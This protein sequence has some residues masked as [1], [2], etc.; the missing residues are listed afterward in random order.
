MFQKL[1]KNVLVIANILVLLGSFSLKAHAQSDDN[2][3]GLE[4]PVVSQGE[5]RVNTRQVSPNNW[6]FDGELTL[7][8]MIRYR[9]STVALD[10]KYKEV[11]TL[12]AGYL[13][14]YINDDSKEENFILDFGSSPLPINKI[15]SKLKEGQNKIMMVFVD[16]SGKI[17]TPGSK[18]TLDFKFKNVSTTPQIKVIEPAPGT[19]LFKD[20]AKDFKLELSNFSLESVN[21]NS[22]NRG[23]IF[24]YYDEI[25]K[26]NLITSFSSSLPTSGSNKE[27]VKFN[28][29]I[30][31]LSKIPDKTNTQF[32]FVLAKS[33]DMLTDYTTN[34]EVKTNYGNSLQLGLPSITIKEPRADKSDLNVTGSQKFVISVENFQV[35]TS[36]SNGQSDNKSGYI[37][38]LV[39][40]SPYQ[41]LW[42]NST[43]FSLD[44][45]RF[46]S[47]KEVQKNIK[48][49]LVNR[50]FSKL[51]TPASDTRTILYQPDLKSGL[52]DPGNNQDS[53]ITNN[54]WRTITII[55]IVVL[56]A[57]GI[58]VLIT[59]G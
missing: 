1:I 25:K 38:I 17:A 45:I 52:V 23:K 53:N 40:D 29:S 26:S 58:A 54:N 4:I 11:P 22:Q 46:T 18:V 16:K 12:Q 55:M 20:S 59:K 50:D 44:E 2:A 42:T 32:I 35:L 9:W 27:E 15:S 6:V 34:F 37:Q 7:D 43:N 28:T 47:P 31:D 49:Q 39:D 19:V 36:R 57:G 56:I 48:V 21:S 30:L 3:I 10:L 14:V 51:D 24:L 33:D 41:I 8:D 5:K 13:K